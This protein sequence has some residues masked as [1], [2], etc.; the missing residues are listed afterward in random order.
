VADVG[1]KTQTYKDGG[2]TTAK[3]TGVADGAIAG[4]RF[5]FK[6]TE[7]LGG[8]LKANFVIEQGLS[9]TSAG[10]TNS[11]TATSAP[12]VDGATT[13]GRSA[14]SIN[15]QSYVGLSS[16]NMGEVRLGYQYTNVYEVS[17]LSGF[18]SGAEGVNGADAAHTYGNA[19]VGGTRANAVT[20]ITPT[21]SGFSAQLQYGA[22][23]GLSTFES[24]VAS[25]AQVHATRTSGML[26]YA[27]GPLKAKLA[28]TDYKN[29]T[30]AGGAAIV[31]KTGSLTQVGASYD[32]G[33][34]IVAG[35]YNNGEDGAAGTANKTYKG[36]QFGVKVPVGPWAFIATMGTAK[37]TS[38]AAGTSED[39][40]Q[41][42][43]AVQ[44]SL[45]KR[46]MLYAYN[47]TTK[48]KAIAATAIDKKT[49]T[50]AGIYHS[51]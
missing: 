46:T 4:Q 3:A 36:Q 19:I 42:Q 49:S 11:R 20:Y 14:T 10:L 34:V 35:T 48:D 17:T 39:I 7:D 24:T 43:L 41:S 2:V 37:T 23:T 29:G 13:T 15:R 25:D 44:Y 40:K 30:A 47:G 6:G 16:A 21:I 28:Y 18:N 45:S 8:G 1:I 12:Q 26:N 33:S 32:F 27:N 31:D 51:F 9:M 5:G 38:T 22:A 50:V